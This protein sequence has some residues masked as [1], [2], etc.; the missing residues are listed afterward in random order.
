M[1]L[2]QRAKVVAFLCENW[3]TQEIQ[4]LIKLA[5]DFNKTSYM[6]IGTYYYGSDCSVKEIQAATN[7]SASLIRTKLHDIELT[8][9]IYLT[10]KAHI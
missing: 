4:E 7:Y 8:A 5:E 10:I 9:N 3:E 1:P 2:K 6:T